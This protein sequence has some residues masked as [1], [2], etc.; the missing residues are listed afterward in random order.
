[1]ND[2]VSVFCYVL[3]FHLMVSSGR[4]DFYLY[5]EMELVVDGS[6]VVSDL[7][8]GL[9]V[10]GSLKCGGQEPKESVHSR[11]ARRDE[12]VGQGPN[13]T[14]SPTTKEWSSVPNFLAASVSTRWRLV[15]EAT[16]EES[17]PPER[18]TPKG[19]SVMSLFT[20]A[21]GDMCQCQ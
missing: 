7:S 17:R 9:Q 3:L 5:G 8:G 21:W 13:K 12:S 14:S 2:F 4:S 11:G 15:T 20:T 6:E 16:R 10:R 1:V 18:R 19:T